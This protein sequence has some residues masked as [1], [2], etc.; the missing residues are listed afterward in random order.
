MH[1]KSTIY[2][3]GEGGA[4]RV[5]PNLGEQA[6]NPFAIEGESGKR[7]MTKRFFSLISLLASWPLLLKILQIFG[8]DWKRQG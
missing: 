3:D 2:I 5:V 4:V 8:P 6:S 1:K 7:T